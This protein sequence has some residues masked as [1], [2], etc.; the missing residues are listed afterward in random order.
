MWNVIHAS[1]T[2]VNERALGSGRCA[3][4]KGNKKFICICEFVT[5]PP[6]LPFSYETVKLVKCKEKI[7]I[8]A[9]CTC[10]TNVSVCE[11][12]SGLYSKARWWS[13]HCRVIQKM[14]Q[15][16]NCWHMVNEKKMK[17]IL[18]AQCYTFTEDC[19]AKMKEFRL[20]A[21]STADQTIWFNCQFN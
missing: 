2:D 20:V 3:R 8:F 11:L 15:N 6:P 18:H 10:Q 19:L 7:I 17:I 16:F 4:W 21:T 12:S 5:L 14:C 13:M 1:C 9:S